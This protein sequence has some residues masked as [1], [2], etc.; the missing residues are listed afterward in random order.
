MAFVPSALLKLTALRPAKMDLPEASVT[1]LLC[2]GAGMNC[3]MANC[4][5]KYMT[6]PHI[7]RDISED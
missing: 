4:M 2:W 5:P 3:F 6:A 7:R 1:V